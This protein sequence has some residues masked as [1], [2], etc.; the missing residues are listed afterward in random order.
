MNFPPGRAL[1]ERAKRRTEILRANRATG[2]TQG[3]PKG[4]NAYGDGAPIV[5]A[6]VTP[7]L[8]ERE[9]RSQGEAEQDAGT[10]VVGVFRM[11]RKAPT[12]LKHYVH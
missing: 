2:V 5:V 3:S 7:R 1:N 8:G 9:S 11:E 4:G 10:S 6:G 12:C